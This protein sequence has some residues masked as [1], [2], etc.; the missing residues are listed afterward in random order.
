MKKLLVFI[1][2]LLTY[3]LLGS[4]FHIYIFCPINE[5]T[6]LHCPGCGITRMLLS[7]L[8]LDFY[9]A[10]RYNPLLFVMFP[11]FIFLLIDEII[12]EFKNKKS[13]LKKI[14]NKYTYTFIF[15]LILYGILRNIIP[16]LAP[17]TI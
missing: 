7:I 8:K 17:T 5:F 9:Q 4:V 12:S 11:F 13:I 1:S 16:Y 6:G 3:I 10:F 15:V 14:P 2:L